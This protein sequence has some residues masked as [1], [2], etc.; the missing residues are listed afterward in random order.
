MVSISVTSALKRLTQE[1][2]QLKPTLEPVPDKRPKIKFEKHLRTK[3]HTFM[4]TCPHTNMYG[5]GRDPSAAIPCGASRSFALGSIPSRFYHLSVAPGFG[6]TL[7]I[8][9][10]ACLFH[11]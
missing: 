2:D 8:Q 6:E 4:H 11:D 3:T 10:L 7:A 5:K 9:T 1:D